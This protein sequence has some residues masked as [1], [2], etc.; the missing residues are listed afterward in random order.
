VT[1]QRSLG[2]A[3][4]NMGNFAQ[5]LTVLKTAIALAPGHAPTQYNLGLVYLSLGDV[6]LARQA[7]EQV[8][9]LTPDS[10]WAEQA[11]NQLDQLILEH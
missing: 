9:A 8:L 3:Y 6:D 5:A 1:A 11:Q 7:F 4:A 2:A 10:Q